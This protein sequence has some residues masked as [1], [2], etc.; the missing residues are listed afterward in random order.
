MFEDTSM[1]AEVGL[2]EIIHVELPHKRGKPIMPKVFGQDDL[3]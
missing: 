2:M 1:I 3:F